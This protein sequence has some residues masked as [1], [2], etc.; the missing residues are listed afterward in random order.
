MQRM[1]TMKNLDDVMIT[2][3][4]ETKDGKYAVVNENI[5]EV[6]RNTVS[7]DEYVYDE[8]VPTFFSMSN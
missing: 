2:F 7:R 5:I 4:K 3:L 1:I 6:P 8:E